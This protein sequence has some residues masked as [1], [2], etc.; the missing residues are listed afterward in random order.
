M[1]LLVKGLL[2]TRIWQCVSRYQMKGNLSEKSLHSSL[3]FDLSP[4]C[5]QTSS[6]QRY[7]LSFCNVCSRH[8]ASHFST[9]IVFWHSSSS[10]DCDW[11]LFSES[12]PRRSELLHFHQWWDP[13]ISFKALPTTP[14][15][16]LHP[17]SAWWTC[18]WLS[19]RRLPNLWGG[20]REVQVPWFPLRNSRLARRL[21]SIT[22]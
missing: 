2:R 6:R 19:Y 10:V 7:G 1:C 12:F 15:L 8:S 22:D 9:L 21:L 13:L 4:S 18:W 14:L 11:G 5:K 16:L 3:I 17:M 20:S